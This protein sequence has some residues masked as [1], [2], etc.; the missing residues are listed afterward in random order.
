MYSTKTNISDILHDFHVK[1]RDPSIEKL[2]VQKHSCLKI[3]YLEIYIKQLS[4]SLKHKGK[5]FRNKIKNEILQ[6]KTNKPAG[7]L[8]RKLKALMQYLRKL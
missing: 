5:T 2:I 4:G 6:N 3:I 1:T 7:P 8:R